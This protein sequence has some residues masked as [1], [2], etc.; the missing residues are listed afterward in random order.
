MV[1]STEVA[2]PLPA[3]AKLP[4]VSVKGYD[5]FTL[6]EIGYTDPPMHKVHSA[7]KWMLL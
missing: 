2:R 5:M 7:L 1:E 6:E 3:P 4:P